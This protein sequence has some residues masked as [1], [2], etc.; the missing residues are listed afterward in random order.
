MKSTKTNPPEFLADELS[1]FADD[2]KLN[3]L[4]KS[5]VVSYL[6]YV[7][8]FADYVR[9]DAS[10]VDWRDARS[11]L[12]HLTDAEF[13][14]RTVN[15]NRSALVK[16]FEVTLDKPLGRSR[17]PAARVRS[18]LPPYVSHE[19]ATALVDA[20][21]PGRDKAFALLG[22]GAGMRIGEVAAIRVRDV[23]SPN[24]RILVRDGKTRR[25]RHTLLPKAALPLLR[26]QYRS[27][28]RRLGRKPS[29][30]DRLFY[31]RGESGHVS[32]QTIR[33]AFNRAANGIGLTGVTFHNL[34]AAFATRLVENG[35]SLV[36]V[37]EFMG[38][39]SLS[40]TAQ[41]LSVAGMT[42]PVT[43]P[44]DMS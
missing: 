12:L 15:A 28:A 3:N 23:D 24:G 8:A 21:G 32:T 19:T 14:A 6:S 4:A 40:T 33:A 44:A 5:T 18:K 29:P 17:I 11:F 30:D 27:L 31:G 1:A 25:D 42:T 22:Y 7:R 16:F 39:K 37:K 36:R 35:V 41:Y 2:L 9:K 26:D 38:H 10:D 43:S 20:H 34:R 13:A